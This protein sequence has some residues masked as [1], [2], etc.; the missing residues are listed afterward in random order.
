MNTMDGDIEDAVR[1]LRRGGLV[2]FPTETVYGLGADAANPDALRRLYAVKGRPR[3][4]PVIVHLATGSLAA[5]APWTEAFTPAARALADACWPGPVTL[6]VRRAGG[7]PAEVTGGS[8]TVAIRVPDQPVAQQLLTRFGGGIAAP[9]A[10]RFGRVSPTTAAHVRADLDTDV[11]I[12]LDG[13]PCR[14]G[15][16]ST[17]VDCTDHDP[18]ILR[19]GALAREEVEA[20]VGRPVP[21]RTDGSRAAPGTLDSH[22]APSTRVVLVTD[23]EIGSRAARLVADGQRVGV[24]T[25]HPNADLPGNVEVLDAPGNLDDLAHE[26]YALLRDADDR[27]LDVLLAVP[28]APVGIGAA[29]A[30]RLTRAAGLRVPERAP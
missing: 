27:H 22:Y 15:L 8:D 18:L 25:Q 16:E 28:P 5:L 2:A 30:D 6:V 3:S 21:L 11:D 17:V 9:S 10:N 13:G 24:L 14:V 12:I 7:V 29:V 4:H 23:H 1:I 19:E 26:L 20:I